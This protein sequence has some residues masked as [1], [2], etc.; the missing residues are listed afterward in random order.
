MFAD[1]KNLVVVDDWGKGALTVRAGWS[2]TAG[3]LRLEP[4]AA[5]NNVLNQAYVGAVTLNG[6]NNRVF[7]PAPLRNYYFGMGIGWRVAR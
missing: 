4:F 1:D 2:G 3:S 6:A 5:V 7:E